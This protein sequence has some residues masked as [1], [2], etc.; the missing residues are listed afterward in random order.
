[1]I[2]RTRTVEQ[3][4]YRVRQ[5]MRSAMADVAWLTTTDGQFRRGGQI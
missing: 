2:V 5:K 4:P 3:V 1:M